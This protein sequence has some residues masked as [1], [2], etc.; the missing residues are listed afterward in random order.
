MVVILIFTVTL[1]GFEKWLPNI[2][3]PRGGYGYMLSRAKEAKE[4]R[5]ID[6]LFIGSSLVYRGFDPRVF[7]KS[8]IDVFNLGSSSQT[9]LNSYYLLKD[10][11]PN[12]RPKYVVM[13][14]YWDVM[15]AEIGEAALDIIANAPITFNTYQMA[16]ESRDVMVLNSLMFSQ[17]SAIL[18]TYNIKQKDFPNDNYVG[19]GFVESTLKKNTLSEKELSQLP[20]QRVNLEK[21]HLDYLQKIID[22]CDLH[23]VKLIFICAPVTKEYRNKVVNYQDYIKAVSE[24]ANCNNISF[25]DYNAKQGV[26][27]FSS[28]Q[29]F[30]DKGHLNKNGAEKISNLFIRDLKSLNLYTELS[31]L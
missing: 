19:K 6:M 13:D 4:V 22:L 26:S 28:M 30:Y 10:Y 15:T 9:P 17:A 5:D 3:A 11:L 12:M 14:L 31:S 27:H 2:K 24:I 8:G 1:F 21:S 25:I 29:D 20:Q 23:E 16:L 7:Q 18:G